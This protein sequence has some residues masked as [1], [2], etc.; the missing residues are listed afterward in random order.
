MEVVGWLLGGDKINLL[1]QEY[2]KFSISNEE[3]IDSGFTQFNAIVTSLKSLDLDYSSKNHV[4]KFL[5]ALPFKWRAKITT[6]EKVK[7]LDLKAKVTREQTSDESDSQGASNEEVDKEE[8]EAFN[9]L[10]RNFRK[11]FSKGNRF[12]CVNRFSNGS[13]KFGKGHSNSFGNKGGESSKPKGACYNCN[14]EGHF[15]SEC[16]KARENKAFIEGSWSDSEDGDE[17]LNDIVDSGCTKHITENGRLFTSYKA[18][19]SGHVVFG[20]NLKGKVV[21]G[22]NITH[23]SITITNVKHVGLAFN[24]ISIGQL[25]DDDCLVNSTKVDCDISKNGKLLAKGHRRNG[26]YTCKLGDNSKQQICLA[27][28]VDKSTLW[29][30]R[31]GHAN[32][33]ESSFC[34]QHRMSYNLSGLFNSQSNEIVERTHHKLRKMSHAML[35]EQSIPQKFWCHALDTAKYIFNRVY[36]RKFINKTL[37]KILR[38]RKPSLEY[39]WVFGC[40]VFIL[41]TKVHLTKFDQTPYEGVFLGYSQTSKEYI[42][43]NKET[44]RIEESLNVTFD[45]SLPEPKSSSLLEDGRI[46]EPTIQDLNGSPSLQVNI[47]DEGYPKSLKDARSHPIEQ[48]I[49][50]LNERTLRSNS[51]QA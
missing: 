45:E 37:Y 10:P 18:Y 27:S 6:K 17:K 13:N 9:L 43:I 8:S 14:I 3:T 7:S 44:M 22:G 24:L 21:D 23:E 40:K 46:D 47:S 50:E 15:D 26:L 42:V 36:I 39:F 29:H 20:R 31:L 5:C 38:N 1:T 32:M 2:K 12:E 4:R 19:D 33:R 16:R 34:E 41:N 25:C 11:F 35:D 30:K 51:G 49:G 28:M 48:L